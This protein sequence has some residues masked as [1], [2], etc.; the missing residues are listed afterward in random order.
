[1]L[2]A[3]KKRFA[4][5]QK[6]YE[7]EG[8]DYS[9][10]EILEAVK[11]VRPTALI[12]AAAVGRAFS[13]P[14]LHEMSRI[15][16]RPIIF[17]LSNPTSKAECSAKE[18]YSYT[19]GSVMFAS[20]TKFPDDLKTPQYQ[21]G[22]ANNAF[23][24]PGMARGVLASKASSVTPNMFLAAAERLS[25]EVSDDDLSIGAVFPKTANLSSISLAVGAAVAN[26]AQR[27][28]VSRN[29]GDISFL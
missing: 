7:E 1:M 23:I 12:G 6:I 2:S 11:K 24:F 8:M 16:R 21:P 3:E 18:A 28:G 20:G 22:F 9:A 19:G 25:D 15:N 5:G 10:S 27:E 14:V 4:R 26:C 13:K 29:K 17:A